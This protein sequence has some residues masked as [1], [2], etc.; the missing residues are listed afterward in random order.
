[1]RKNK[2]VASEDVKDLLKILFGKENPNQYDH[3]RVAT[4]VEADLF[5][6]SKYFI[7]KAVRKAV[8]D[9]NLKDWERINWVAS[10]KAYF[11]LL[12]KRDKL[13]QLKSYVTDPQPFSKMK[14]GRLPSAQFLQLQLS[15][16]TSLPRA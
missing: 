5:R 2:D 13:E 3:P 11:Q 7:E 14:G 15:E 16:D 6:T 10:D 8:P 1:M 9:T 12:E 4:Q